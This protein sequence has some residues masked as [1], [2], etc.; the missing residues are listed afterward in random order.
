MFIWQKKT[1][2]KISFWQ[3]AQV[4][5]TF[6]FT[7][8]G[9]IQSTNIESLRS[10]PTMNIIKWKSLKI[11]RSYFSIS[12]STFLPKDGPLNIQ[13]TTRFLRADDRHWFIETLTLEYFCWGKLYRYKLPCV[14]PPKNVLLDKYWAAFC[15]W[16]GKYLLCFI[17]EKLS[18]QKVNDRLDYKNNLDVKTGH[19]LW[20]L[21][22]WLPL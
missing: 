13:D 17:D 20:V 15:H 5:T 1:C 14:Y 3:F 18:S 12:L 9:Y 7:L 11:F 2:C 19:E 21:L 6:Y 22:K 16:Q 10:L 8:V 4:L